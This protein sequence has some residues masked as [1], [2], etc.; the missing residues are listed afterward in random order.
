MM[1]HMTITLRWLINYHLNTR[2]FPAVFAAWENGFV[3]DWFVSDPPHRRNGFTGPWLIVQDDKFMSDL[4]H[5]QL[6]P[7]CRATGG[8]PH[9]SPR[10]YERAERHRYCPKQDRSHCGQN[11][12]QAKQA[13]QAGKKTRRIALVIRGWEIEARAR[14]CP[15]D[16]QDLRVGAEVIGRFRFLCQRAPWVPENIHSP[17]KVPDESR[18]CQDTETKSVRPQ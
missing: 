16:D 18:D 5:I 10:R 4:L 7:L 14:R 12:R 9:E 2:R 8:S 17:K 11:R 1:F 15:R 13:D 6:P 3:A